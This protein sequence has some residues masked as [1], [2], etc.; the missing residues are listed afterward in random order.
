MKI[1][2]LLPVFC[3]ALSMAASAQDSGLYDQIPEGASF[4]RVL[5]FA[6]DDAGDYVLN[7]KDITVQAVGA[8]HTVT[9][10]SAHLDDHGIT[11]EKD[12]KEGAFYS[13]ID[14]TD[15]EVLFLEDQKL[16]NPAKS[17]IHFYNL[18]DHL[19]L[20]LKANDGKVAVTMANQNDT[21]FREINAIPL[22]LAIYE[23]KTKISDVP[24]TI[25]ER[26][27]PTTIVAYGTGED[28]KIIS[29]TSFMRP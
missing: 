15:G 28:I 9:A 26:G 21:G 6:Q 18:T 24:E 23:D 7:G 11:I 16:E 12:I 22:K 20:S 13:F 1:L 4:V 5:N 29:E 2:L 25:L 8:Y 3:F 14:T 17:I 27:K 10:K 19:T